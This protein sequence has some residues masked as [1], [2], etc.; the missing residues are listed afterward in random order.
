[1]VNIIYTS[2]VKCQLSTELNYRKS[3]YQLSAYIVYVW[4]TD[5]FTEIGR[6]NIISGWSVEAHPAEFDF[7]R[8]LDPEAL[9]LSLFRL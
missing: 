1:M 8:F 3:A 6:A 7:A 5:K 4:S 2:S 9:Y